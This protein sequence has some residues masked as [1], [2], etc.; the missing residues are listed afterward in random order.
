M[1]TRE[2]PWGW[3]RPVREADDLPPLYCRT[4]RKSGAL[5]YAETPWALAACCGRDLIVSYDDWCERSFCLSN[6][7]H[8]WRNVF[9]QRFF[10]MKT[11]EF[12]FYSVCKGVLQ[13]LS[14]LNTVRWKGV[15]ATADRSNTGIVTLFLMDIGHYFICL[16][17]L[18]LTSRIGRLV[19]HFW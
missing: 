15:S 10:K 18:Q 13:I 3:R 2:F 1:G 17:S 5:T 14:E 8:S 19:F 6:S 7:Q 11:L 9:A 16:W 12:F 4:S